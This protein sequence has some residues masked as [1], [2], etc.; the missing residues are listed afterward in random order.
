MSRRTRLRP[1]AQRNRR[2]AQRSRNPIYHKK[3][4]YGKLPA[5]TQPHF[6]DDRG[7][8][9]R[10]SPESSRRENTLMEGM[11]AVVHIQRAKEVPWPEIVRLLR[12]QTWKIKLNPRLIDLQKKHHHDTEEARVLPESMDI[13]VDSI[14][15]ETERDRRGVLYLSVPS[16]ATRALYRRHLDL[17]M[18]D[19]DTDEKAQG[20]KRE[21]G[22]SIFTSFV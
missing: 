8:R 15:H 11:A 5:F 20:K 9:Y 4:Q 19:T 16:T 17:L 10:I 7:N 13:F 14:F 2:I 3:Y 22:D 18:P 12:R 6:I 1:T 21:M